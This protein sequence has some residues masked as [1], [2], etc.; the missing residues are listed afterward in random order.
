MSALRELQ[1][2]P[3][4]KILPR[5]N[6]LIKWIRTQ[7]HQSPHATITYGDSGAQVIFQEDYNQVIRFR[8]QLNPGPP[9]KVVVGMGTINGI[10]P[11][12]GDIPI[13]GKDDPPTPPP[14]IDTIGPDEDTLTSYVC[15]KTTHKPDGSLD[16]A[17]VECRR[18]KN[19]PSGM[20][21]DFLVLKDGKF[22]GY[23]PIALL[24]HDPST[25]QPFS[26]Y[27][28]SVHNLQCRMYRDGNLRRIIYWAA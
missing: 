21:A 11:K 9:A 20:R 16:T 12:V 28:H 2:Q 19:I 7:R 27:Q 26:V 18:P 8:V 6:E 13:I 14:E 10:I 25:L 3:G 17:T 24:Y 22:Y 23:I 4:D 1:A 5:W 15:I